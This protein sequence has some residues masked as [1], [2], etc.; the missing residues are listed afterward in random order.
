D[1]LDGLVRA[2]VFLVDGDSLVLQ[3]GHG[4]VDDRAR[5]WNR[6]PID[7]PAPVAEAVRSNEPVLLS[8]PEEVKR[9]FP[10]AVHD[11]SNAGESAI[12]AYPLAVRGRVLG[13][14][15]T[16]FRYPQQFDAAARAFL[17]TLA[18]QCAQALERSQVY[19]AAE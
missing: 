2:T 5:R 19:E 14:L 11:I 6:C 15:T 4:F 17:A 7:F 10:F 8:S 13:A 12:A 1:A 18:Q 3:S 16:G 9:R